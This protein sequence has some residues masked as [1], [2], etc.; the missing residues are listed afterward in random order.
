MSYRRDPR[1][2]K[3]PIINPNPTADEIRANFGASDYLAWGFAG[4]ISF[5]VGYAIGE[6]ISI[7]LGA[8]R[9]Y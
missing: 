3:Y 8:Y 2:P 1:G 6:S 7:V 9:A 5:P 4:G